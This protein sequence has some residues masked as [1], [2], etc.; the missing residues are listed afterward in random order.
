MGRLDRIR[1]AAPCSADWEQM[2]G[3]DRVRRCGLCDC[4][5]YNLSA[6]TRPEAETLL[7][8]REGRTCAVFYRRPDG[9]VLTQP[10]PSALR[11]FYGPAS[12]AA[13]AALAVLGLRLPAFAAGEHSLGGSTAESTVQERSRGSDLAVVAV[14]VVDSTGA[15]IP[16][17]RISVKA[18]DAVGVT[19][20]DEADER[21]EFHLEL[22]PDQY[23]LLIESEGFA[24]YRRVLSLK[25]NQEMTL[26][27]TLLIGS[28][29]EIILLDPEDE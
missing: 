10:C 13:T 18:R 23:D 28:V 24:S 25:A 8:S 26:N 21:G 27:V 9:T 16:D 19:A 29:G 15:V 4:N 12:R 11:S 17:A 22:E 20:V 14:V 7:E 6:M 5:V 2:T 1:H 3:D